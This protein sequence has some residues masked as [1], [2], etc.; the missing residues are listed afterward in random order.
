VRPKP[1]QLPGWI[2]VRE[3]RQPIGARILRASLGPGESEALAL[4]L[5]VDAE[6]ILLDDKA[7]RRLAS[8]LGL[9]VIGIL[10]VLL[11]AK[12]AGLIPEIRP[13][14]DLLRTLPFHIGPRLHEAVLRESGEWR[15]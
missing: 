1:L 15:P 2:A 3:L 4:A 8:S 14:L 6:L 7:A 11:K 12:R 9:S 13:R 10:G 5:E